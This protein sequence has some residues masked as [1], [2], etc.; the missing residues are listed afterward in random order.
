MLHRALILGSLILTAI[1]A[2]LAQ[3]VYVTDQLRI[4]LHADQSLDSP[5]V[6][7]VASGTE[8]D[9][10][11]QE[12]QLSFVREP[13]GTGGWVDNSYLVTD[14][15]ANTKLREA[16]VRISSL[17][18]SLAET[19]AGA[20]TAGLAIEERTRLQTQLEEERSRVSALQ[21][22]IETLQTELSSHNTDSL[23]TKIDELAVENEALQQQLGSILEQQDTGGQAMPGNSKLSGLYSLRNIL[24][25][26]GLAL[27]AGLITGI[28]LMDLINRKRHG[29]FRI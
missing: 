2:V 24:I 10:V 20:E 23:Y 12:S 25:G 22:Q 11:K 7:V 16:Q 29:G 26:L 14:T 13:G 28:Y 3:T 1:P 17:E 8:L 27:L 21:T 6:M 19:G 15:A 4:G 18:Q 5:I 9:L